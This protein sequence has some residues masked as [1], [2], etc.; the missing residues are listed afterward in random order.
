MSKHDEP[1]GPED[2]RHA[3]GVGT[4]GAASPAAE[5]GPPAAD[6]LRGW[7]DPWVTALVKTPDR[8]PNLLFLAGYVGE[9]PD[10]ECLRI[11]L[12]PCLTQCYDV[13]GDAVLHREEIPRT[14][15]PLG[16]SYLWI[17][18]AQWRYVRAYRRQYQSQQHQQDR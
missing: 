10:H 5:A 18:A 16:G 12:D 2:T 9:S 1:R 7:H 3:T 17:D 13:P 15:S 4:S 11:Y 6:A 8:L 14:V